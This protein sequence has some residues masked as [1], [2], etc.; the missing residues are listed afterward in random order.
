M[1]QNIFCLL[2]LPPNTKKEEKVVFYAVKYWPGLKPSLITT[3]LL[4][5]NTAAVVFP[6]SLYQAC[7][8]LVSVVGPGSVKIVLT[9]TE[10]VVTAVAVLLMFFKC[11]F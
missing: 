11:L 5:Y 4:I 1:T 9:K 10:L 2:L 6:C 7:L 8:Q 3:F